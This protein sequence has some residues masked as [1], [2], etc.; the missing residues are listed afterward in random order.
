MTEPDRSTLLRAL[1]VVEGVG[2]PREAWSRLTEAG[3]LG[4][5]PAWVARRMFTPAWRRTIS[6]YCESPALDEVPQTLHACL[7]LAASSQ[8]FA[9]AEAL[10]QEVAVRWPRWVEEGVREPWTLVWQVAPEGSLEDAGEIEGGW[11]EALARALFLHAPDA[12]ARDNAPPPRPATFEALRAQHRELAG[13]LRRNMQAA[14]SVKLPACPLDP[15]EE[16]AARGYALGDV[17]LHGDWDGPTIV[18]LAPSIPEIPAVTE[19]ERRYLWSRCR[20]PTPMVD[21]LAATSARAELAEALLALSRSIP[22]RELYVEGVRSPFSRHKEPSAEER[23]L[24]ERIAD[25]SVSELRWIATLLQ[26]PDE[27]A[28]SEFQEFWDNLHAGAVQET[29]LASRFCKALRERWPA[30]PATATC[31]ALRPYVTL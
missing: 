29:E 22:W 7:S 16:L 13:V 28:T 15:A 2:S 30:P 23:A 27:G 8:G 19:A 31:D 21:A 20:C 9:T 10:A 14:S 17:W 24:G 18:L 26:S 25:E 11:F 6:E 12:P 5:K 3:L 4:P 1:E